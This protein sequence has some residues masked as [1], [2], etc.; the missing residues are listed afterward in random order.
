MTAWV[1]AAAYVL[2]AIALVAGSATRTDRRLRRR[3]WLS[4]A[5][6]PGVLRRLGTRVRGRQRS[7]LEAADRR[8]TADD[9]DRWLGVGVVLALTGFVVGASAAP[10]GPAAVALAG[11][12][13]GAGWRMPGFVLA[14]R[15]ASAAAAAS[16]QAPDVLDTVAISVSAGLSPRLALDRVPDVVSPPL[17]E[18]LRAARAEVS[19]GVP[20]RV[21]LV[22][23]E[24][25]EVAEL[26]RLAGVLDRAERL[27]TPLA[28]RLRA[29]ARDVRAERRA[30]REERARRAPVQMLFPLVFLIL[31]AFLLAAVV[32]AVLVATRDLP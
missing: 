29:V 30:R 11:V 21:A 6:R 25:G 5:P 9:L 15:A 26:R 31:P 28:G 32:P 4:A 24:R 7:R 19:L 14:R 23:G 10:A 16:A 20:W 22:S 18:L 27:G 12:L 8:L 3:L 13:G 17:G 2:S 1:A